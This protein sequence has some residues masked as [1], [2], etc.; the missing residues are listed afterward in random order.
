MFYEIQLTDVVRIPPT[1]LKG[2]VKDMIEKTLVNTYIGTS[3]KDYGIIVTIKSVDEISDG[4]MIFEDGGV[5]YKVKFTVISYIPLISEI[6]YGIVSSIADFGAFINIGPI[7]G[8]VHISQVMDDDVSVS[9]KEA[10]I[11]KN[12]RRILKVNDMVIT[13]IITVSYKGIS[14]LRVALTMKQP[15]LGKLE[16][17][18]QKTKS[19]K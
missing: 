18:E 6:T 1:E 8:L 12:S 15:G 17:L 13:R 14:S 11:G 16:W 3:S 10:L 2:D 9:G 7:D 4:I 19:K 5:Y